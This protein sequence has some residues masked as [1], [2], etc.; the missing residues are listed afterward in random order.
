M[1]DPAG[2]DAQ[3]APGVSVL[4]RGTRRLLHTEEVKVS[5]ETLTVAIDDA[6]PEHDSMVPT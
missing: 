1:F 4:P 2:G 3:H 5:H 6:W